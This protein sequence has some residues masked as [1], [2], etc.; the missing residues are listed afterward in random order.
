MELSLIQEVLAR[1][2][3]PVEKL[4]EAARG[5]VQG[6]C[7]DTSDIQLQFWLEL[8][9]FNSHG[10]AQAF[11]REQQSLIAQALAGVFD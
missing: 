4:D 1:P 8:A 2:A 7:D 9:K 3:W 5:L 6:S 11:E 10:D